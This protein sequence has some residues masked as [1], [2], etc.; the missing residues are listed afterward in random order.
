MFML[1]AYSSLA[2]T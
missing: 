2:Q 1:M